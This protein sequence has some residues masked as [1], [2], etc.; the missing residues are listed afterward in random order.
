MSTYSDGTFTIATQTGPDVYS[1]DDETKSLIVTRKMQ[2]AAGSWAA[3]ARGT[4]GPT[5]GGTATKLLFETQPIHAGNGLVEWERVYGELPS[6]RNEYESY[7]YSYQNIQVNYSGS[8]PSSIS[9]IGGDSIASIPVEVTSRLAYAYYD[10]AS[11]APSAVTLL[12]PFLVTEAGGAYYILGDYPGVS[13]TELIAESST[14]RRWKNSDYYERITRY[15][16]RDGLT[17]AT[18]APP[19]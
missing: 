3:I 4:A 7:V 15:V 10:A 18:T 16:P 9:I 17:E 8:T 14:L 13:D 1:V 5:V 12:Q 19:P 2:I 11:T 6:S